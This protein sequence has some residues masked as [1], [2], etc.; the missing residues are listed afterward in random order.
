MAADGGLHPPPRETL[1]TAIWSRWVTGSLSPNPTKLAGH[2]QGHRR[3][4]G[5][6]EWGRGSSREGL[7]GWARQAQGERAG[8][9]GGTQAGATSAHFQPKR[10]SE[11]TSA[12]SQMGGCKFAEPSEGA[13][14]VDGC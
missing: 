11:S 7:E 3:G 12:P 1:P 6:A 10:T 13:G 9:L 5:Q 8:G 14:K 2:T 4:A